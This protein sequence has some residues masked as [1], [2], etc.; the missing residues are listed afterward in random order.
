MRYPKKVR[1][2]YLSSAQGSRRS[3]SVAYSRNPNG[4]MTTTN[5][6]A[7]VQADPATGQIELT[8]PDPAAAPEPEL[9]FPDGLRD[10]MRWA[11]R[12][13]LAEIGTRRAQATAR[14]ILLDLVASVAW[15]PDAQN[16]GEAWP[17]VAKVAARIGRTPRGAQKIMRRLEAGVI[18]NS[19]EFPERLIF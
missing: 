6:P 11:E 2:E 10:W 14:A 12:L 7:L 8:F 9:H 16:Y 4:H 5:P 15:N 19:P 13:N 17:T 3:V 1:F 18:Y